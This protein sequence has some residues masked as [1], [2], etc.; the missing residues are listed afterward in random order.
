[1]INKIVLD[2]KIIEKIGEGAFAD[3]YKAEKSD[4]SVCAIKHFSF[5]KNADEINN[6]LKDGIIRKKGDA[7]VYY[8]KVINNIKKE[9]ETLKKIDNCLN[10]VKFYNFYQEDKNYGLGYDFY[11]IM[12]YATDI[13]KY[14]Y[15]KS[16]ST[17]D[18]IKLGIDIC[19]ALEL[20]SLNRIVHND[21][22]PSN[23]FIDMYGNFKLGDF[24]IAS[25]IGNGEIIKY[26]SLDYMSPDVYKSN[27][28]SVSTD[29][30]SLGLVMYK[31][32]S[33]N[34]PFVMIGTDEEKAF[35]IRMSG[36]KIPYINNV[37]DDLMNI[38]YKACAFDID[39]R[40]SSAGEMKKDLQNYLYKP[41]VVVSSKNGVNFNSSL[42]VKTIGIYDEKILSKIPKKSKFVKML[43]K[44]SLYIGFKNFFSE[45]A[46]LKTIMIVLILAI[47]SI[48]TIK[49]YA[50]NKKCDF[51]YINNNGI[52]VKGYYFC[53]EG[54]SL[55]SDNKCQK[56]VDS[57]DA[58]V[59]FICK[60]GYFAQNMGGSDV[61]V[62]EDIREPKLV[63]VCADGF[64]LNN[65]R[66]ERVESSD[67]IITYSCPSGYSNYGGDTCYKGTSIDAAVKYSCPD[68]SY[69][70]SGNVCRKTGT[71]SVDA[72][73][74]YSCTKGELKGTKCE[75]TYSPSNNWGG[76]WWSQ[77]SCNEGGDYSYYDRMCHVTFEAVKTYTCDQGT[78]DGVSKCIISN[79]STVSATPNYSCPSGYTLVSNQC[80]K[81]TGVAANVKYNCSD[82]AVLKGSKCYTTIFT[83]TVEMFGCEDGFISSGTMC[84][85]ND[86]PT[87][88][89]KYTCSKVYTLNGDK[90]EKYD[91]IDAKVYLEE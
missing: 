85:L 81:T 55:N 90:C 77:G 78:F 45:N 27:K 9:V 16:I 74:E 19:K 53:K 17:N 56:I 40:Y 41:K 54:Y 68:S 36:K 33:G 79:N 3:V 86:F 91:I 11:I 23:I 1:M 64:N 61:C 65:G 15:N 24:G 52:C 48:F 31:L 37:D 14:Y 57:T 71:G 66:C 22:K 35:D 47:L 88:I 13:T 43:E 7:G 63:S 69:V 10:I 5:P 58:T 70:L 38:L 49:G 84:Y 80:F 21:I 51:G 34:L 75:Y 29:L 8:S 83:N 44:S 25:N 87:A 6:L 72:K 73:V 20:C 42:P 39:K 46:V 28:S 26:G 12:E 62:S 67:A 89:K 82:S 2:W 32:L 59:T 60:D 76:G 30:Y 4:G 50:L 18:V